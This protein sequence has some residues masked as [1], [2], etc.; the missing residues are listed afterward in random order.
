MNVCRIEQIIERNRKDILVVVGGG[1]G[2][3]RQVG[4]HA[5]SIHDET[6]NGILELVAWIRMFR[7]KIFEQVDIFCV[8]NNSGGLSQ[9]L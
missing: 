1:L 9:R 2:Y 8:N 7:T 6:K 4:V 3:E 5:D